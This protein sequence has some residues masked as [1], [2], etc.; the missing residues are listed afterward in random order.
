MGGMTWQVATAWLPSVITWLTESPDPSP[1]PQ[2]PPIDPERVTPG[3]L[4]LVSFLFLVVAVALLYRS[5]RKQMSKVDPNLPSGAAEKR[6][7]DDMR[8]QE[9]AEERGEAAEGDA[10]APSS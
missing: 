5:L 1:L 2:N 8:A 9:A 3:L 10:S 4:G 7:Q 6:Y